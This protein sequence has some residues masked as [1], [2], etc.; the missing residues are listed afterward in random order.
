MFFHLCLVI[1]AVVCVVLVVVV[2]LADWLVGCAVDNFSM[3]SKQILV[4]LKLSSNICFVPWS[5]SEVKIINEPTTLITNSHPL[6][7]PIN[8]RSTQS[9]KPKQD[10]KK[11]QGDTDRYSHCYR[12]WINFDAG[13]VWFYY[14]QQEP[15]EPAPYQDDDDTFGC[16]QRQSI[17]NSVQI[18]AANPCN[19]MRYV[20]IFYIFLS[21]T[22]T[23][24]SKLDECNGWIKARYYSRTKR[25]LMEDFGVI[26]TKKEKKMNGKWAK[27]LMETDVIWIWR[28]IS[29]FIADR[30]R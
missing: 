29:A 16:A 19:R 10:K 8:R 21:E 3:I 22:H 14:H 11:V 4:L 18:R 30:A 7:Q 2:G 25:L 26:P 24:I 5:R 27:K 23:K 12:K 17:S 6:I 1:V 13:S 15:A 28:G 20:A 9:I